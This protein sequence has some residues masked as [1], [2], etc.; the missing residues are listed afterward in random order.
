M[1][2]LINILVGGLIGAIPTIIT[3]V[4]TINKNNALQ[5]ERI[6]NIQTE[7]KDLSERVDKHNNYGLQIA[8]LETRVDILEKRGTSK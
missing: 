7:I 8:R 6:S 5:D 3:V 2:E 4:A 1:N